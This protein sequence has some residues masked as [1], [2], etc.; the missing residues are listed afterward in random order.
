LPKVVDILRNLII[1]SE[2]N[3]GERLN[4]TLIASK[5]GISRSPVR[6]AIKVLESEDLVQT[7][8]RR[9][10][11][12]KDLTMKEVENLYMV[13]SLIN[14][15]TIRI[16]AKEMN[17]RKR[18]ELETL[19]KKMRKNSEGNDIGKRAF[20]ARRFHRFIFEAT[21]NDLLL[22]IHDFL[23]IQQERFRCYA[24]K[25]GTD[26]ASAANSEHLA[27][28]KSL[29]DRDP[30]KAESMIKEHFDKAY[31]RVLA[32]I[33]KEAKDSDSIGHSGETA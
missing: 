27:I 24:L 29:L 30:D 31:S 25:A 16:A 15:P 33:Q 6:E 19:M 5:L 23:G 8:S 21:E 17:A 9:G 10:T 18:K 4:E 7:F 28:G 26:V 22:K 20:L 14:R 2:L 12:V 13:L 1:E 3:P 32:V 11:F